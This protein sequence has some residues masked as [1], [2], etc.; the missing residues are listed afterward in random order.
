[1]VYV[2]Y[3]GY[4]IVADLEH[5]R[6][7]PPPLATAG[8]RIAYADVVVAHRTVEETLVARACEVM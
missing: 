8:Q 6:V 1:M 2:L 7:V 4:N 3:H 5:V